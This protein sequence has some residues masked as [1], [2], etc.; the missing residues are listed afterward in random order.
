MAQLKT[1]IKRFRTE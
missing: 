1:V